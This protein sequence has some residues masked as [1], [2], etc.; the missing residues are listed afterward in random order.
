MLMCRVELVSSNSS[1]FSSCG[2]QCVKVTQNSK[3]VMCCN[4]KVRGRFNFVFYNFKI[5]IHSLNV[6]YHFFSKYCNF[7]LDKV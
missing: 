2:V 6:K 5:L 7:G 3:S 1:L 4:S